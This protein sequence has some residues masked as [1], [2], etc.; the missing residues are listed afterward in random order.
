VSA[1]VGVPEAGFYATRLVRNGIEV[2]V[3]IWF[4]RPVIDGEEQDRCPRWCVEVDGATTKTERDAE[5]GYEARVPLDPIL[6][7]VWPFC[8]RH[9]IDE[10]EFAHMTRRAAWAREFAPTHPAA[11]PREPIDM[12]QLPPVF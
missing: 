5:T 6:D 9:R 3:R 1:A 10:A 12:R 11:R 2:P 7:D 4:G 8:A